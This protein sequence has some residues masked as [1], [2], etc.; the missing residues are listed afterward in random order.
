[1]KGPS[2]NVA[3]LCT[4]AGC[5]TARLKH[6][7]KLGLKEHYQSQDDITDVVCSIFGLPLLPAED[8]RTAAEEIRV[9]ICNDMYMARQLQLLLTYVQRQW[10]DN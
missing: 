1:M 2:R 8:I 7:N 4:V 9:T 5:T 3:G 6:L 10:L